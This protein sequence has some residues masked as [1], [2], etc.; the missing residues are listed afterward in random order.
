M[1]KDGPFMP[2]VKIT[3]EMDSHEM[4]TV[5]IEKMADRMI[6]SMKDTEYRR[7]TNE[8]AD[9]IRD[10]S[11]EVIEAAIKSVAEHFKNTDEGADPL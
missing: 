2:K 1:A 7:I 8:I 4:G 11:N 10:R 3:V 5:L 6:A 9:T